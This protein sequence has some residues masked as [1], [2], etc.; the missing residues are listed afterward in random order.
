MYICTYLLLNDIVD[1]M[2]IDTESQMDSFPK[3][4]GQFC[5]ILQ[6]FLMPQGRLRTHLGGSY[7]KTIRSVLLEKG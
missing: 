5:G 7:C 1:I 3:F 4:A 2:S 6:C